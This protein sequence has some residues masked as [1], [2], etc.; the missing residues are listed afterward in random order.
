MFCPKC[1]RELERRGEELYCVA[2]DMGLSKVMEQRLSQLVGERSVHDIAPL[3]DTPASFAWFCPRCRHSLV[4]G[5]Q[6]NSLVKHCTHCGLK[7]LGSDVYALTELHPHRVREPVRVV[8]HLNGGLTKVR[9][10][11]FEG[12]G[13]A[14]GGIEWEIP[15]QAIPQHLRFIGSRFVIIPDLNRPTALFEV[16]ELDTAV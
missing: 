4:S 14:D 3:V 1:G 12:L 9:L 7:L 2:G 6:Q 8:M 13:L 5:A 11:R 10:E 15:T 16:Q